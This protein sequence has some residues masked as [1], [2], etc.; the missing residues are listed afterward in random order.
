MV[1]EGQPPISG[2]ISAPAK[3][4]TVEYGEYIVSCRTAGIVTARICRGGVQGQA[5]PIGPP[6]CGEVWTAEQF[7]TT[8]R[9]GVDPSGHQMI[10]AMP[11]KRG[12]APG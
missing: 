9:T 4:P 11:W 10:D 1:P 7:I 3:A 2:V 5:A 8:L 6:G 12:R